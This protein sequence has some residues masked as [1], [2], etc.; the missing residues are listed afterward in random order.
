MPGRLNYYIK[1]KHI[2]EIKVNTDVRKQFREVLKVI[3]LN[4]EFSNASYRN[5]QTILNLFPKASPKRLKKILEGSLRYGKK[6]GMLKQ[7]SHEPITYDNFIKDPIILDWMYGLRGPQYN[8]PELTGFKNKQNG[9]TRYTF[10]NYLWYF[11]NW[12]HKKTITVTQKEYLGND[13]YKEV[14]KDVILKGVVDFVKFHETNKDSIAFAMMVNRYLDDPKHEKLGI[15]AMNNKK[16]AIQSI[17]KHYQHPL[18]LH[19]NLEK[20]HKKTKPSILRDKKITLKDLTK[21][22]TKG[23]PTK[24]EL[25]V[26]LCEFHRGLDRSTMVDR[27]NFE[28]WP[29]LVKVFGTENFEQWDLSLCPVPI[30]LE[31][32]KT[33]FEHIGFLDRDAIIVIQIYL[34]DRINSLGKMQSGDPLFVTSRNTPIKPYW[35]TQ[36]IPKLAKRAEIQKIIDYYKNVTVNEKTTHELRDLLVSIMEAEGCKPFSTDQSI[37]HVPS[38]TYSKSDKIFPDKLRKEYMKISKWINIFTKMENAVANYDSI[39]HLEKKN[40]ELEAHVNLQQ[41]QITALQKDK[42]NQ[43]DIIKQIVDEEIRR[44]LSKG[45]LVTDYQ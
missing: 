37:G 43:K 24:M 31:R 10:S 9:S 36:L 1:V 16:L 33:D 7:V 2:E 32:L 5:N 40:V 17:F 28:A 3:P 4:E 25:A 27:F 22:L 34:P 14:Q 23:R 21:M 12:I 26:V 6:L 42:Q 19:V 15:K 13:T 39:E 29:Q 8:H 44:K 35:M 11:N 38:G 41:R 20:R 30:E 18:Q 45:E